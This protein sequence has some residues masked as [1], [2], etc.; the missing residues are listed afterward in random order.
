M[1]MRTARMQP[2]NVTPSRTRAAIHLIAGGMLM[3]GAAHAAS[4]QSATQLVRF[5]V[6]AQ[7]RAAVTPI[8]RPLAM[9]PASASAATGTLT[10][11]SNAK[12]QKI[13]AS[14]DRAMP[15]GSSLSATIGAPGT[16]R[17]AGVRT[18]GTRATDVVTGI[19]VTD[20]ARLPIAYQVTGTASGATRA[21]GPRL[22]T[23]T[24]L[25]GS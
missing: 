9:R 24:I 25:A 15:A 1:P 2:A 8:A 22:V 3:L 10:L 13:V 19:A 23:Y 21:G 7:R 20:G 16:G 5:R 6:V 17:S 18:L 12:N 11:S 4:A 14:I